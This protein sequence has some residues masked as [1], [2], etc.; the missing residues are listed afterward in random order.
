MTEKKLVGKDRA[1]DLRL[2]RTYGIT[3]AEYD[4]IFKQQKARCAICKEPPKTGHNRLAV[5][6]CHRSGKVRGLLCWICNRALGKFSDD[7][8]KVVN[9]AEYVTNPPAS[10]ALGRTHLT[11]PGRVGTAK[12]A[13]LLLKLSLVVGVKSTKEQ[14]ECYAKPYTQRNTRR[15]QKSL[16]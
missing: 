7:D 2:R 14:D 13:K 5:D 11:A 6:H 8:D 12:R 4:A 15:K 9:A 3:L 1:T 10:I 16:R